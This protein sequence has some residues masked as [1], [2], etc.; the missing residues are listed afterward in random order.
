M[1]TIFRDQN[2]L[3]HSFEISALKSRHSAQHQ[4]PAHAQ[5]HYIS[6]AMY[7]SEDGE[8]VPKVNLKLSAELKVTLGCVFVPKD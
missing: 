6:H 8:S 1:P 2:C 7:V 4:T 3:P 5:Y